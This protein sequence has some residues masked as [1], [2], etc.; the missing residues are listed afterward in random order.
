[1]SDSDATTT[2]RML[3]GMLRPLVRLL[4]ARGV[5][6]PALYRLLKSVYVEVAHRDFRIDDAP[7]TDSRVT[8]LTG[9]HR[10]D[11]RAILSATDEAWETARQKAATSATVLGR[12]RGRADLR[13]ADGRPMPLPRADAGGADFE[14]LAGEVSRDVRPRTV[15][16]ELMRQGLVE[17]RDGLLHLTE[18]ALAGPGAADD[19]MVFFAANVGDHL[20]AATE[21]VLSGEPRFLERAVF[22]NRLTP[23]AVDAVEARARDLAQS[24]LEDLNAMSTDLQREAAGDAAATE[25]YRF[26]VYLLREDKEDRRDD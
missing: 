6:A 21:N 20:A 13:D 18:T 26:G 14:T 10:R 24:A 7:P 2:M 12:W 8:I 11:V 3:R 25:R 15:L 23:G 17:E 1:M 19:R 5:T 16:D 4:I 9:V 22:F